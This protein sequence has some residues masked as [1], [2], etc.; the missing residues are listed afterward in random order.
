[1]SALSI[2]PTRLSKSAFIIILGELLPLIKRD[3]LRNFARKN[4][5]PRG[6]DRRGTIANIIRTVDEEKIPLDGI[7]WLTVS[8]R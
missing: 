1:M 7:I 5:I 4:N 3:V 8:P 2:T 6:R